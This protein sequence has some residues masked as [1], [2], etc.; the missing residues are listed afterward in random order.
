M[1]PRSTHARK[2]FLDILS[3]TKRLTFTELKDL[4]ISTKEMNLV[5]LYRIIDTFKEQGI[6]HELDMAGERVFFL[7][8]CTEKK[9]ETAV[10][11][12]YCTKCSEIQDT[13]SPVDPS[14]ESS[15]T[16]IKTK[17]CK[18]CI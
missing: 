15:Q 11:I 17:F 6:I 2:R 14:V 5:T 3:S 9:E 12:S 16:F 10:E 8:S 18:N 13:H 1:E 4:L 7:C